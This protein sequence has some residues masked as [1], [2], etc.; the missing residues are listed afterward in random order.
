VKIGDFEEILETYNEVEFIGENT[1]RALR[2]EFSEDGEPEKVIVL[3][4]DDEE[5][6]LDYIE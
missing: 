4:A 2:F 1:S 5:V 3:N 6:V